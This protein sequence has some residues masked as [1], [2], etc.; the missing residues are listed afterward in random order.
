[1]LYSHPYLV[2]NLS[3]SPLAFQILFCVF[4]PGRAQQRGN[5]G[6]T[7]ESAPL[8]RRWG[9]VGGER[10]GQLDPPSRKVLESLY[11][12]VIF[13]CP[14]VSFRCPRPPLQCNEVRVGS[15]GKARKAGPSIACIVLVSSGILWY[16]L[17]PSAQCEEVKVGRRRN[18]MK[19]WFPISRTSS[20]QEGSDDHC[21]HFRRVFSLLKRCSQSS[22]IL[23]ILYF[24]VSFCICHLLFNKMAAVFVP[25]L[26]SFHQK[27]SCPCCCSL[28]QQKS[29][30]WDVSYEK[31]EVILR[32]V[33]MSGTC[34]NLLSETK[35]LA[36]LCNWKT[37]IRHILSGGRIGW[38]ILLLATW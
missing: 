13:W 37:D 16:P 3:L 27:F 38:R 15:R 26:F 29:L 1:M 9:W 30:F 32:S 36:V 22:K 2:A 34:V 20:W 12:L 7:G 19:A 18:D 8:R 10:P 23:C 21:K 25:L 14:L 31:R 17:V 33:E 4:I 35:T 28:K 5:S 11:A 24:L 6:G